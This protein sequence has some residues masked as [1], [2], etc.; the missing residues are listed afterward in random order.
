LELKV[1]VVEHDVGDDE[2]AVTD[3]EEEDLS[4]KEV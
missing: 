4:N 1:T 3:G 2:E